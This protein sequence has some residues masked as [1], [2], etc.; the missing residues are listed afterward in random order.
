MLGLLPSTLNLNT[1]VN[2]YLPVN[3]NCK[4]FNIDHATF[5][6]SQITQAAALDQGQADEL[7]NNGGYTLL[8]SNKLQ[9]VVHNY[10]QYINYFINTG[11]IETDGYFVRKVDSPGKEKSYGY[12]FTENYSG[13][14]I[15]ITEYSKRFEKILKKREKTNYKKLEKEYYHLSKWLWPTCQLNIDFDNAF[16][17]LKLRRT[18][19]WR[20]PK[21][22]DKKLDKMT[23]ELIEKDPNLQYKLALSSVLQM[24]QGMLNCVVDS[25]VFRMHTT[26]TSMKSELRNFITYGNEKMVSIDI[27]NSQP[28]IILSLFNKHIYNKTKSNR[29]TTIY[30]INNKLAQEITTILPMS[31]DFFKLFDNEDVMQ[32]KLLVSK[33]TNN[34]TDIYMYMR[35]QCEKYGINYSSR[36]EVKI[37][38]FEV[39]FTAN[40]Y[41]SP[42]KLLFEK[43]FPTVNKLL[44]TIKQKDKTT[45]AC[46]LQSIE[47]FVMLKVITKRIA[48]EIPKAPLFTIHDSVATTEEYRD[49]VENI[50]NDELVK[51]T[52]FSPKLKVDYWEPQNVNWDRY[53]IKY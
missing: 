43:L 40:R 8:Y 42:T 2:T 7:F 37:R 19:Q 23:G 49:V 5:V 44:V 25:T 50:M 47:S 20:F 6:L 27:T 1:H 4:D 28:Y 29:E 32:Y 35:N 12:R 17:Y 3:W 30:N 41:N 18:C 36:N 22:R 10:R 15:S 46:L 26:L 13:F 52:G 31:E 51:L 9:S 33:S 34:E 16:K 24:K 14:E 38:M 11:V 53:N 39:L 48:T 21:A 45:L